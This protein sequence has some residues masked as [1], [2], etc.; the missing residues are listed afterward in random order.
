M[1]VVAQVWIY[2]LYQSQFVFC[3]GT[4]ILLVIIDHLFTINTPFQ[5]F[6]YIFTIVVITLG[7]ILLISF[8]AIR[9]SFLRN[10]REAE[11]EES[12]IKSREQAD[13]QTTFNSNQ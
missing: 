3:I 6:L 5:A 1:Y 10:Q 4:G 12:K 11:I 2:L 9:Q 13:L 8:T 7:I